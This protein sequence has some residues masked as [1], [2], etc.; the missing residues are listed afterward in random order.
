MAM[1]TNPTEA[2]IVKM[3]LSYAIADAAGGLFIGAG[4]TLA[5]TCLVLLSSET[6]GPPKQRHLLRLYIVV[7]M[8]V[9]VGFFL[10]IFLIT[11]IFAIFE[12]HTDADVLLINDRLVVAMDVFQLIV[13]SMTDGLLVWRC[14]TVHKALIGWPSSPRGITSWIIPAG[15]WVV[16]FVAG[17]ITCAKPAHNPAIF[18]VFASNAL[19]NL[20]GTV[21]ITTRLLK[22]RRMIRNH[23]G[24]RAPMTRYQDVITIL[25]ESAMINVPVSI[26]MAIGAIVT[27]D[28]TSFVWMIVLS[29]TVPSQAFAT[30][31]V[32]HQ[33][34]LGRAIGQKNQDIVRPREGKSEAYNASL[35]LADEHVTPRT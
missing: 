14:Y 21:I 16:S 13:I 23:L 6:G 3:L 30:F 17:I 25:L 26:C 9:V 12:P 20:C 28:S 4:F 5:V 31:L 34:A 29:I 1:I 8:I 11:N 32:I 18:V 2:E 7:L 24:G 22:H 19:T 15:L 10:S 33:M 35:L 27:S